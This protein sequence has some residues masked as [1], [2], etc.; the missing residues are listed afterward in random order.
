MEEC[1]SLFDTFQRSSRECN[2]FG[3]TWNTYVLRK[4]KD[5]GRRTP[6]SPRPPKP[7]AVLLHQI[8]EQRIHHVDHVSCVRAPSRDKRLRPEAFA[9]VPVECTSRHGRW[10][11]L[12][13][14]GFPGQASLRCLVR[15]GTPI[16]SLQH[17]RTPRPRVPESF[18]PQDLCSRFPKAWNI[19]LVHCYPLRCSFPCEGFP[20]P[21][22][23][24]SLSSTLP[25]CSRG[26]DPLFCVRSRRPSSSPPGSGRTA[27]HSQG[28]GW[29]SPQK[30]ICWRGQGFG[31]G[32]K[33]Q[34]TSTLLPD[35]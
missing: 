1:D 34:L 23:H 25:R 28:Q 13:P 16:T 30:K 10:L 8:P 14:G 15:C 32:Q 3:E 20:W 17:L 4:N 35:H 29:R 26:D 5:F 2:D 27:G 11:S 31:A 12:H 24:S 19:L 21:P 18:C 22:S 9:A 6:L 7:S 33:K